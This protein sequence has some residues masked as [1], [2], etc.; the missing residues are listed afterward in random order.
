VRELLGDRTSDPARGPG[1]ER[2]LA[3]EPSDIRI[4]SLSSA[5]VASVTP[6]LEREP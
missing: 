2:R 1:D 3:R 6:F 4:H 5:L